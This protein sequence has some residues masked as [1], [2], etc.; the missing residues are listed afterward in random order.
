MEKI[1]FLTF[2]GL[3]F[4]VT[5][6]FAHCPLC[7]IGAG[8]IASIAAWLG[9]S[10]LVIG[11]LLGAFATALGLWI[12]RIIKKKYFPRQDL[13]VAVVIFL[14]TISPIFPIAGGKKS[15]IYI[16]LVGD[17]GSL[18]NRTY[19]IDLFL[20]GSLL[21][22]LI[23]IVSPFLSRKIT[24]WRKGKMFPYQ[25]VTITFILLIITSITLQFTI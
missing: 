18:L 5:P 13:V 25:G 14:S 8:V 1:A 3:F 11:V 17:Y 20:M 24:K 9:V 23:M 4:L 16:S 15:S 12:A 7:T 22:A 21:G 2:F 6:A 10:T 19:V